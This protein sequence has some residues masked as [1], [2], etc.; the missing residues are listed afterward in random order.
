MNVMVAR[1]L[2]T[3]SMAVLSFPIFSRGGGGLSVGSA[4]GGPRTPL[5]YSADPTYD[6]LPSMGN[7]VQRSQQLHLGKKNDPAKPAKKFERDMHKHPDKGGD[8]H[9]PAHILFA[10][11]DLQ[12]TFKGRVREEYFK[13]SR[14]I[15]MNKDFA[16]KYNFWRN[17]ADLE[18]FSCYGL[19]TYGKPSV[20]GVIKVANFMNWRFEDIY[21]GVQSN[22]PFI[23]GNQGTGFWATQQLPH[24]HSNATPLIFM[25][26]SWL[27]VHF[28]TLFEPLKNRPHSLQAGYFPFKVGRGISLGDAYEGG[29]NYMGWA[30]PSVGTFSGYTPPHSP[31]LSPGVLFEGTIYDWLRYNL[32]YSKWRATSAFPWTVDDTTHGHLIDPKDQVLFGKTQDAD[33]WALKLKGEVELF[34]GLELYI[35]PYY[36]N[37][38]AP[39]HTVELPGDASVFLNT[40]GLM[41]DG[42]YKNFS[43]NVEGAFQFGKFQMHALDRNRWIYIK[44]DNGRFLAHGTHVFEHNVDPEFDQANYD[45]NNTRANPVPRSELPVA[46]TPGTSGAPGQYNLDYQLLANPGVYAAAVADYDVVND[47]YVVATDD[48]ISALVGSESDRLLGQQNGSVIFNAANGNYLWSDPRYYS[49]VRVLGNRISTADST[50]DLDAGNKTITY[51]IPEGSQQ[52]RVIYNAVNNI[53]YGGDRFRK[54]YQLDLKGWMFLCD[55]AY[56]F[57]VIPVKANFGG[58]IISGDKYPFNMGEEVNKPYRGFMPLRDINYQGHFIKSLAVFTYRLMPRPL[59]PDYRDMYARNHTDDSSNLR[60]L[61]F[62]L[63]WFPT[64]KKEVLNISSNVIWFWEDALIYKWDV[65][66]IPSNPAWAAI[67]QNRF[68]TNSGYKGWV[69][70]QPASR[71]LGLEVN[72]GIDYWLTECCDVVLRGGVFVPGQL[73]KDIKGQ[74]NMATFSYKP[75]DTLE[76]K[77]L[78]SDYAWAWNI[79]IGY[80]F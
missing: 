69:S 56:E 18:F 27:R 20:E 9:Y 16:D 35:E 23:D 2:L 54:A 51:D 80:R 30:R 7:E 44:E 28:D 46:S 19:E 6:D 49:P 1:L 50:V 74:A 68:S 31:H 75:N 21:T 71:Y 29:I 39:Q 65:N 67:I 48:V 13:G 33:H 24:R 70:D 66:G 14:T 73:Y 38:K 79:R 77:S 59:N 8:G 17:R 37:L 45:P 40:V 25:E 22:D 36:V 61:G 41:V 58:G 43:F 4:T 52:N 10:R 12:L 47:D 5:D 64:R 53:Q 32:Y 55:M 78:G 63:D 26:E 60:L 15:T 34:D 76:A 62:G 42:K 11:K 57:D 72:V 3:L